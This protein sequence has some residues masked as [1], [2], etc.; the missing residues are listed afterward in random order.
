MYKIT[1]STTHSLLVKN[2]RRLL[3]AVIAIFSTTAML[4]FTA[5]ETTQ[6]SRHTYR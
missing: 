6:Y 1:C 3:L 4:F 5:G 2:G